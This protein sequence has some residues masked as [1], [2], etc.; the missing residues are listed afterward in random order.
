ML[1]V[2]DDLRLDADTNLSSARILLNLLAVF[3]M[4]NHTILIRRLAVSVLTGCAL[5]W[6]S[7]FLS[8]RTQSVSSPP[9]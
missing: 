7:S 5:L 4:A 2:L 6:L 8:G 1:S 3:N 9:R